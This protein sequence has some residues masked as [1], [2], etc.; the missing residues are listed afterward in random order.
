MV[1]FQKISTIWMKALNTIH[2]PS[3]VVGLKGLKQVGQVTSVIGNCVPP[4]LV[5][6]RVNFKDRMLKGAPSGS[7]EAAIK[8]GWANG[9]VF[10]DILRHLHHFTKSSSEFP[11]LLIMDNHESHITIASLEF[12][13]A[14]GIILLTLP[15]HTSEKLQPLDKA[16]C[17]SLK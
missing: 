17:K 1:K 9:E 7:A 2:N 8:T 13:K 4:F 15:P 6:P 12:C 10:I 11:I 14:N 5:F 16:L 3:N